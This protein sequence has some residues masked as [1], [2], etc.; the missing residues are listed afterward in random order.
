MKILVI[1]PHPDDEVVGCGGTIAKHAEKLDEVY[2]CIVTKGYTPDWSEELLKNRP[3]EVEKVNKILG[4][5]KTYFLDFPTVKLDTI[6]QKNLNDSIFEVVTEVKPEI[7]YMPHKGDLNKDHRLVFEATLVATRP[8]GEHKV[9]KMLS[10]EALSSTEWGN[11]IEAFVPNVYID[12]SKTIERKI[13]AMKVYESEMKPYPHPRSLE[14]VD[15]LAK[16][17][18]SEVG[19][20]FAEAFMLIKEFVE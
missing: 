10:Y 5:K 8:V 7:V 18:G 12:V 9:R 6:P 20:K 3:K 19:V 1:A 2:L 4:I 11:P 13:E 14:V 17:R 15:A 16:K